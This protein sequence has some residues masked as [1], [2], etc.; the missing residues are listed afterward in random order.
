MI[1]KTDME[2]ALVRLD[3]LTQEEVRMATAQGLKATHVVHDEVKGVDGHVQQ[4]DTHVQGVDDRVQGVD[5][6]V[7]QVA[8]DMGDQKRS[9]FNNLIR[10]AMNAQLF[11]QAISY[12]IISESGSL[13]QIH[14]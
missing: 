6:K 12:G 5:N 1:G 3:R 9:S 8:D 7:Q 14:L 13:P 4:V 2:D 11:S 10:L